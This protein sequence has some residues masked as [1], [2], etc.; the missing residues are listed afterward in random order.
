AF[1]GTEGVGLRVRDDPKTPQNEQES[2]LDT[3]VAD[4]AYAE[5]GYSQYRQNRELIRRNLEA[6][7]R[8]GRLILTGHSLGGALAQIA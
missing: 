6:A 4:F 2:G 7:A 3:L 5:V 8:R 1:R